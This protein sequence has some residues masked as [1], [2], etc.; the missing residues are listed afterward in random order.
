MA[1]TPETPFPKAK[2]H[3]LKSKD[4]NDAIKELQRLDADKVNKSGDD[5]TGPLTVA[6]NVGI[7]S[8]APQSRLHVRS[9]TAIDEGTTSAGAWANFGS[10]AFFDGAWKRI[11]STKAGVSLHM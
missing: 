6:G 9:L 2:G 11:D 8:T 3:V 1:F 10:N 5:V 7:G 4:W